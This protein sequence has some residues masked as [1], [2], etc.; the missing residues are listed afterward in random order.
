[1]NKQQLKKYPEQ[2]DNEIWFYDR[3]MPYYQLTNFYTSPIEA[4]LPL[5]LFLGEDF[6]KVMLDKKGKMSENHDYFYCD[7]FKTF[8]R[9]RMKESKILVERNKGK[10]DKIK[11]PTAEH[12]FQAYKLTDW[13][14]Y[15][16]NLDKEGR[17]W[18]LKGAVY[19]AISSTIGH[20]LAA[21][22][23]KIR[24]TSSPS[25]VRDF[26]N[27]NFSP[28]HGMRPDWFKISGTIREGDDAM[29]L[30]VMKY[31]V[32]EKFNQ[33]PRLKKLL[34]ETRDK[35]L[36]EHSP[37]D[38]FWGDGGDGSGKNWLGKILM[39]I[40]QE[41]SMSSVIS[42]HKEWD[43]ESKEW[44]LVPSKRSKTGGQDWDPD[45][46]EAE[47]PEPIIEKN[48]SPPKS[49][50]KSGSSLE[51]QK[52][53]NLIEENIKAIRAKLK[54]AGIT[55]EQEREILGNSWERNGE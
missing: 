25:E 15:I 4:K 14:N 5:K 29:R 51:E 55:T 49:E 42:F 3:N 35:K 30:R 1:M 11:W 34:W 45:E 21:A 48:T 28:G 10:G 19:E 33:N 7:E 27:E 40:R 31:V 2:P 46:I 32:R 13:V 9:R 8:S 17:I 54:E 6:D 39:E 16:E 38:N 26:V 43:Y 23:E 22:I 53:R 18:Y 24:K 52:K 36:V 44:K 50:E 20:P 41:I 47:S 37:H 12:L